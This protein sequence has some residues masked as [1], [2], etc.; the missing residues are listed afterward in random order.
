[1]Y[2]T[3]LKS[4]IHCARITEANMD[5]EGSIEIDEDLMDASGIVKYEKVLIS[6]VSN[7]NR[8]ETYV[9][10]GKRGSGCIGLNGAAARLGVKGDKVIIFAFA[11]IEAEKRKDFKPAILL[12]NDDNT[13]KKVIH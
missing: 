11:Q 9:I 3:M 7:A 5:Y 6:N 10:P 8:F 13:I 1:M 2:I 12:I 4:K